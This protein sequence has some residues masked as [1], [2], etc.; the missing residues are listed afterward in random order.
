MANR[1]V[2]L[3]PLGLL[4]LL[5]RP[6][7]AEGLVIDHGAIGCV[8][9][10]RFPVVEAR[11]SPPEAVGHARVYFRGAGSPH[12]YYVEMKPGA[13][14]FYGALPKPRK[15]LKRIDYY[16]EAVDT[17]FV[18]SRTAEHAPRVVDPGDGCGKDAMMAAFLTSAKVVVGGAAGAPALPA[19]FS[20][21]GV[22]PAGAASG[23]GI[24]TG[25]VVG[26]VGAGA[27]VAAVAMGGGG[28]GGRTTVTPS[29]TQPG[30]GPTTTSPGAPTT[31]MAPPPT[32]QPSG[33]LTGTWLGTG[34][35]GFAM[36]R[37]QTGQPDCQIA[38]DVTLQ[39]TQSGSSLTGNL[40]AVTRAAAPSGCDTIGDRQDGPV[41]GTVSGVS[42]GLA[43]VEAPDL[44]FNLA[45][46][47]SGDNTL[48]GSLAGASTDGSETFS[49]TWA[50]VRQ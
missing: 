7:P 2:R 17:A 19:G 22:V 38:S 37:K 24:S 13:G 33:S 4:C 16:I 1:L 34:Q 23:G 45:G 30:G 41:T 8:V 21:V 42:V 10:E 5:P 27:A 32:T 39:L 40:T 20:A 3:G 48:S 50:V 25:L 14:A 35:N 15:D 36:I 47:V 29:T 6:A 12:W 26:V 28:G 46:S 11:L 44:T 43:W 31:T 18:S 49:G 9:A